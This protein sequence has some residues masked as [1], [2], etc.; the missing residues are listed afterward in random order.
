MKRQSKRWSECH[1]QPINCCQFNTDINRIKRRPAPSSLLTLVGWSHTFIPRVTINYV[2]STTSPVYVN[3][4]PCL[5]QQPAL[6]V[7][8]TSPVCV[9]NQP[10][11]CQQPALSVS[12]TS[13][14][15]VNNQPCLCQQPALSM[16]TVS[17]AI[18]ANRCRLEKNRLKHLTS[19]RRA[20]SFGYFRSAS[21]LIGVSHMTED[22]SWKG[23]CKDKLP[24]VDDCKDKLTSVDDCKDKL[25]SVDDCKDKLTSVDDCKDKLTSVD[26][27]KEN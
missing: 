1:L 23:D 13:P 17:Y 20:T 22:D 18:I 10:C 21:I 5:C 16:S 15:S 8:T 11:L 24:S 7:S 3:N 12:T 2:M 26:D 6:S 19:T 27:C 4:Q 9:N 25:P 14:V